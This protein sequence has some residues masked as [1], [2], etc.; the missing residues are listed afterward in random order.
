MWLRER[1]RVPEQLYLDRSERRSADCLTA[2]FKR[3]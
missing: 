2:V 1:D 3:D